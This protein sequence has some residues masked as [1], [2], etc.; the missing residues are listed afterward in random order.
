[1]IR[2]FQSLYVA[3]FL[4]RQA[5]ICSF[6]FSCAINQKRTGSHIPKS[7]PNEFPSLFL[8][9]VPSNELQ[10]YTWMDATLRELTSLVREVNPEARK[11]GTYFD[12]AVISPANGRGQITTPSGVFCHYTSRDIGTTVSGT[13]GN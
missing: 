2:T 4:K 1:M 5:S 10:I 7:R 3:L 6:C 13:K 12:F 9:K 11:K 8:G